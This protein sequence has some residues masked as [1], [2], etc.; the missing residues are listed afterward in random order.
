MFV[1]T[2]VKTFGELGAFPLPNGEREQTLVCRSNVIHCDTETN[3]PVSAA[4][5]FG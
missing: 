5:G 3:A 4:S 1:E 2:D